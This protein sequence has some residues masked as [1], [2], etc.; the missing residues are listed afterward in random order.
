MGRVKAGLD[1]T[2]VYAAGAGILPVTFT[3]DAGRPAGVTGLELS[4]GRPVWGSQAAPRAAEI[5]DVTASTVIMVV[6]G[7]APITIAVDLTDGSTL[8]E[9][10]GVAGVGTSGDAVVVVEPLAGALPGQGTTMVLDARTGRTRWTVRAPS[11]LFQI[12]GG[13]ALIEVSRQDRR[14]QYEIRHLSAGD[15]I[16]LTDA[17]LDRVQ[18]RSPRLVACDPPLLQWRGC[19]LLKALPDGVVEGV[20]M[21]YTGFEVKAGFGRYLWGIV[22]DYLMALDRHGVRRTPQIQRGV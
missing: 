6:D 17:E 14:Q 3:D 19:S 16:T 11:S 9:R 10:D 13:Y 18:H 12:G 15:E 1:R 4:S 8:W 22:G 5:K 21:P 20:R 7:K 2:A